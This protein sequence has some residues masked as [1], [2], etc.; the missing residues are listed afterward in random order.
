MQ[1]DTSCQFPQYSTFFIVYTRWAMK[2][3]TANGGG[4][5][6]SLLMEVVTTN[7][8][9]FWQSLLMEVASGN[10]Y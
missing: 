2:E 10:H 8:G 1:T 4:F 5:W 7:G 3:T 9:G 6:E